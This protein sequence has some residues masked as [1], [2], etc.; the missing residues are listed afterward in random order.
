MQMVNHPQPND[1]TEGQTYRAE[2]VIAVFHEATSQPGIGGS[3]DRHLNH[4]LDH[5]PHGSLRVAQ[6]L[7][8]QGFSGGVRG[9]WSHHKLLTKHEHLL[10]FDKDHR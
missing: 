6:E 7:W 1:V 8:L 10:R 9:V 4:A 3:R 5:F 2:G